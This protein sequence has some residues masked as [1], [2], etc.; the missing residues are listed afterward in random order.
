[1]TTRNIMF[2]SGAFVLCGIA[3]HRS[4]YGQTVKAIALLFCIALTIAP[5]GY[6]LGKD[7]AIRDNAINAG[8][9]ATKR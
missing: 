5:I 2:L 9:H 4:Q 3:I 1:M 8:I 7:M 6:Q